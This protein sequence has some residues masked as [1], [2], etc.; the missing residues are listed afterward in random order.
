V[1]NGRLSTEKLLVGG[2]CS[3]T[4]VVITT[5]IVLRLWLTLS[6]LPQNLILLSHQLLH[7]RRLQWWWRN[8]LI[9]SLRALPA[10]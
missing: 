4:L 2:R 8:A 9:L 5:P 6:K 1:N 3:G 7:G 10:I